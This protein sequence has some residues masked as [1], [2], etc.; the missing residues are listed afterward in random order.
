[1]STTKNEQ[2]KKAIQEFMAAKTV[3]FAGVSRDKKKFSYQA[4]EKLVKNN[5]AL[6]P[7]NPL[8]EE[9]NG[10]KCYKT[11]TEIPVNVDA[12]ISMVPKAQTKEI[13][14]QALQKNIRNIWVQQ[15]SDSPE[16][17]AFAEQNK[18]N[19][20]FGQCILM[21]TEPV[22]S[23]HAFHRWVSKLFGNYPL[24]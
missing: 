5:P 1:M 16:A 17:L 24:S 4:Y 6:I 21:Y 7:V 11:L 3:A 22:D 2:K 13:L 12:V 15:S 9:V 8:L 10:T 20:I 14:E 18:M 19:V 23:F